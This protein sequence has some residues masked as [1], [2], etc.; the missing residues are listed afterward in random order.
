M[1]L[2]AKQ[3]QGFIAC[4]N[5]ILSM[6][7]V[8]CC[9]YF[10][11]SIICSV[12]TFGSTVW[13]SNITDFDKKRLERVIKKASTLI[14]IS[15]D[16]LKDMTDKK[17]YNKLTNIFK[18]ESHPLRQEFDNLVIARSGR[19]RLPKVNTERYLKSFVPNAV[20]I[21]NSKYSR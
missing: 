8:P 16:S 1:L 19:L 11:S 9:N 4:V 20:K 10:F 14:G 12:L 7:T 21:F 15:Q 18:D 6:S 2:L 13:G 3:I 5:Y 17:V